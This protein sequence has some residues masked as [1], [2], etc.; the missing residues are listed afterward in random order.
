[1]S[2]PISRENFSERVERNERLAL[3]AG[4][5]V[6]IGLLI[7]SGPELAHSIIHWVSP[8]RAVIGNLVVTLG[9]ALEVLFSWR[10]L[11]TA[12]RVE[13]EANERIPEARR[14]AAEANL[15][16]VRL[17]TELRRRTVSRTLSKDEGDSFV[18]P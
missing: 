11:L 17:E 4:L 13:L 1:M 12:R 7:E 2:G 14:T 18:N 3:G 8:S 16:R 9:V 15:A 6:V 10:T 5:V